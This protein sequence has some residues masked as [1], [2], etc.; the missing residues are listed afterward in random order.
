REGGPGHLEGRLDLPRRHLAPRPHQEE[1]DLE[2]G[3]MGEGPE[4]LDVAPVGVQ[5]ARRQWLHLFHVSTYIEISKPCQADS[6][7]GGRAP[8]ATGRSPS[9]SPRAASPTPAPVAP[10]AC[11]RIASVAGGAC[12]AAGTNL[13]SR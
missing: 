5:P 4:G 10:Q 1:E 6:S 3:E 7:R 9:A 11:A 12:S 8:A 2:P 13:A